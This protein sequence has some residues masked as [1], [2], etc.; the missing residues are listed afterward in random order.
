MIKANGSNS[1]YN[2][3]YKI[4]LVGNGQRGKTDFVSRLKNFPVNPS[5][6]PT[7]GVE[8][9]PIE[10][11]LGVV[12][13]WDTAGQGKYRGLGDAYY[14]N[15]DGFIIFAENTKEWL[16]WANEIVRVMPKG[17]YV[18]IS[19]DKTLCSPLAHNPKQLLEHFITKINT[20]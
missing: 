18:V 15:A 13:L 8:V 20:K 17:Y 14:I 9:T 16:Y 3:S 10:T 12:K 1:T 7:Q 2:M 19:S 5:Y 11:D 4:V 6:V